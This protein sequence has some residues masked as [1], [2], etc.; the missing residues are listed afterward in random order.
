MDRNVNVLFSLR[1]KVCLK[2]I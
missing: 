2:R 1:V